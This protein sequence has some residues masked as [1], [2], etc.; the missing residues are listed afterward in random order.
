[1]RTSTQIQSIYIKQ[2]SIILVIAQKIIDGESIYGSA[3]FDKLKELIDKYGDLLGT[4]QRDKIEDVLNK[5]PSA[6]VNN[7]IKM[8]EDAL[9]NG[10]YL[11]AVMWLGAAKHSLNTWMTTEG[12]E[13]PD[14]ANFEE[15]IEK[16][17]GVLKSKIS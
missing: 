16:L 13:S 9:E 15:E 14:G 8:V 5:I 10:D 4:D 11:S 12:L 6:E 7:C 1:M 2:L 17:E 3:V